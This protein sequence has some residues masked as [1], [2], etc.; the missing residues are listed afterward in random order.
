MHENCKTLRPT[1]PQNT[2]SFV[3]GSG[4]T[5]TACSP[6]PGGWWFLASFLGSGSV[7]HFR[8]IKQAIPCGAPRVPQPKW[9]DLLPFVQT[10]PKKVQT[11][12]KKS[13]CPK[14]KF[15]L[16][17]KTLLGGRTL[18]YQE[19]QPNLIGMAVSVFSRFLIG[20][21]RNKVSINPQKY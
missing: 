8:A 6:F 12:P 4:P 13:V 20:D 7:R 17:L 19:K 2:A 15:R 10:C 1:L 21:S 16:A 11:C 14:N 18:P 5:W 3:T 9:P